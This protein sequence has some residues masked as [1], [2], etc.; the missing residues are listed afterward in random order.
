MRV[1]IT[2]MASILGTIIILM[3]GKI[4]N[5]PYWMILMGCICWG[6]VVGY[7]GGSSGTRRV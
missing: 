1:F 5:V 7:I 3:L 6:A 2:I 4:S